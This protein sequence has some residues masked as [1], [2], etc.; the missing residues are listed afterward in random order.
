MP[1]QMGWKLLGPSPGKP[2]P[3][4]FYGKVDEERARRVWSTMSG[5]FASLLRLQVRTKE[6]D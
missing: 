5:P 6:S 3:G 1:I 4:A 2:S